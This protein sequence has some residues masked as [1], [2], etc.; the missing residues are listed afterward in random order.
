MALDLAP[1]GIRVVGVAPGLAGPTD[2]ARD[3][4]VTDVDLDAL[5]ARVPVGRIARVEEVA[6]VY[7]FLA[8]D[9]AAH[10]LGTTVVVDGGLLSRQFGDS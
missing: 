1:Y 3:G 4:G 5:D 6:N 2:L 10:V 8:S 7:A 9:E